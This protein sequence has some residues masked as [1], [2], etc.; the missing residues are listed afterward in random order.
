MSERIWSHH[1]AEGPNLLRHGRWW[2]TI[3][4][5]GFRGYP[6][7]TGRRRDIETRVEWRLLVPRHSSFGIGLRF[8]WGTNGSE[9]P[10]DIAVH[11]SRLGDVWI[12]LSGIVPYRWLERRKPN[13][14]TDYDSRVFEVN[15]S[16]ERF[17]WEFWARDHHWSRSDPWWMHQSKTWR[18]LFFGRH[19]TTSETIASGSTVVPMPERA[20]PA[21]W[22]TTRYTHRHTAPLGRLRDRLLGVRVHDRT[23][24][25]PDTPIPVPGKGEN[26]WD[27]GD[28]AIWSSSQPGASVHKAVAGLVESALTQ[29]SRHGGEHMNALVGSAGE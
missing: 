17:T 25:T 14:D 22:E 28:D 7:G 23:D 16:A 26:S 12:G 15:V 11:L 8:K 3:R 27:C 5:A 18:D 2:A 13:G 24:I 21:R 9:T 10:I 6:N 19:E 1:S 4:N 29:R 20:Y